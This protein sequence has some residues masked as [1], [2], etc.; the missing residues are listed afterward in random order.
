MRGSEFLNKM[1][2]I[3]PA[4]VEAADAAPER[5]KML[6]TSWRAALAA[7]I[8]LVLLAGTAAAVSG[9][10]AT[11][12]VEFFSGKDDKSGYGETGYEL[13]A[14]IEKFPVSELSE[15][16]QKVSEEIVHQFETTTIYSS[17][18]PGHW[19]EKNLSADEAWVFI[20]LESLQKPDWDL[21][22]WY[23]TLNIYGDSTGR[24]EMILIDTG[25]RAGDIRLQAAA[26]IYTEN[27]DGEMRIR[28]ITEKDISFTETFR[29]TPGGNFCQIIASSANER[30]YLVLE[31]YLVE[32]GILYQLH[33]AYQEQDAAQA[34]EL[35]YQWADMF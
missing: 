34:E 3:D 9:H 24:I 26:E 29:P 6:W 22:V 31:G 14:H 33:L 4:Y 7:C 18:A 21:E 19:Q 20:G 12:L 2:L 17:W 27:F 15:N 25:Y 16:L 13:G 1:E 30:G 23:N 32:N 28:A 11:W 35:L 10:G 5:K 8:C